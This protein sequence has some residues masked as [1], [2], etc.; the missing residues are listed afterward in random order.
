MLLQSCTLCKKCLYSEFF[1]SAFSRIRTE[2]GSPNAGEH[3]PEKFRM[4]TL[5]KQWHTYGLSLSTL[6]MVHSYLLNRKRKTKV[7]SS[8]S[9]WEETVFGAS[10][11]RL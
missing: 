2:Y 8:D 6:K 10:Q 5:F 4:R 7:G 3:R 11:G 9:T 1:W